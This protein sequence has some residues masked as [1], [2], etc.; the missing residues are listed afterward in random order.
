M[1]NVEN[2]YQEGNF[3]CIKFNDGK[4]VHRLAQGLISKVIEIETSAQAD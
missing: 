3:F 2:T 1:G 4:T